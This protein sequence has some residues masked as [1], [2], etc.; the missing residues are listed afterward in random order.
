MTYHCADINLPLCALAFTVVL[1]FLRL[2]KP[3]IESYKK[4]FFS[5][6]WMYVPSRAARG[7]SLLTPQQWKRI[8]YCELDIV[9]RRPH[10]GRDSVSLGIRASDRAV[11]HRRPRPIRRAGV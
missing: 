4:V 2:R 8:D 11:G 7:F 6:D 9:H 5:V 1:I 10:V 3:P